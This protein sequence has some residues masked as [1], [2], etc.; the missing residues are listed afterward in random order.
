[1]SSKRSCHQPSRR[2]SSAAEDEAN[3]SIL[4]KSHPWGKNPS[5]I[6]PARVCI[7]SMTPRP[8]PLFRRRG[9]GRVNNRI[10]AVSLVSIGRCDKKERFPATR[11]IVVDLSHSF[12]EEEPCC[13]AVFC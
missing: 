12:R 7:R 8:H 3:L 9:E 6:E 4:A 2:T 5:I 13:E 11:D 10:P 1:M